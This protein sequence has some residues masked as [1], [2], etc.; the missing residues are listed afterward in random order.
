MIAQVWTDASTYPRNP[1]HMGLAYAAFVDGRLVLGRAYAGYGTSN[2]AELL[3]IHFA[4]ECLGPGPADDVT[5]YTDSQYSLKLVDGEWHWGS[6]SWIVRAIRS[7]GVRIE[8]LLLDLVRGHVGIPGNE[9]SNWAA[10]QIAL[11]GERTEECPVYVLK[12]QWVRI[13]ESKVVTRIKC[14][15][16]ELRP[17]IMEIHQRVRHGKRNMNEAECRVIRMAL[18]ALGK[19]ANEQHQ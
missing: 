2:L 12:D 17:D 8:G 4:L 5:L 3:A 16:P 7:Y 15:P 14:L 10:Y 6:Y 11:Y 18:D 13:L 1:G 9:Q 19:G